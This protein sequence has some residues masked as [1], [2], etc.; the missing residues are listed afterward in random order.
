MF[1][2]GEVWGG[3]SQWD[4]F[5]EEKKGQKR[6][7]GCKRDGVGI[8]WCRGL[9]GRRHPLA[10]FGCFYGCTSWTLDLVD[11][12][13]RNWRGKQ[14]RKWLVNIWVSSRQALWKTDQIIS[15]QAQQLFCYLLLRL[16]ETPEAVEMLLVVIQLLKR[17]CSG[18][19]RW[20]FQK[21]RIRASQ[22]T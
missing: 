8:E 5:G 14:D 6:G 22:N 3:N 20:K 12:I 4:L 21:L 13:C 15:D 19:T 16:S 18:L 10:Y 1:H 2:S 9:G 11:P 17:Y 7:M